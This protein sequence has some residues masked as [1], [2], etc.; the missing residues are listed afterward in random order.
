MLAYEYGTLLVTAAVVLWLVLW[1]GVV[2]EVLRRGD[3]SVGA[4][5]G[6]IVLVLVLPFVGL[7]IYAL[8]RAARPAR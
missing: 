6:W 7:F 4:K 2:I 3:L 1:I 8:F 5:A